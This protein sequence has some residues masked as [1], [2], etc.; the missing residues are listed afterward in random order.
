V[1]RRTVARE[2]QGA[3]APPAHDVQPA[4]AAAGD[5]LPTPDLS[6]RELIEAAFCRDASAGHSRIAVEELD[7]E[8]LRQTTDTGQRY[9]QVLELETIERRA[10]VQLGV[11]W[12]KA[13]YWRDDAA[14]A[15]FVQWVKSAAYGYLDN[16]YKVE[17]APICGGPSQFVALD[18]LLYDIPD[19]YPIECW[20]GT[21][22]RAVMRTSGG[23]LY[24]GELR[25]ELPAVAFAH[26]LG[27]CL[28]G[29]NDEYANRT[30][31]D[32]ALTNDHSIMAD[33][34]VEG[35]AQAEFKVR[36]FRRVAEAIA[37][38]Y[39]GYRCRLVPA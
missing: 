20:G 12:V 30:L 33:F 24:E 18:F 31:A 7:R 37:R 19:G 26:E 4:G 38:H 25:E 14:F 17:L 13:G 16:K 5:A 8:T 1:A 29:A 27:H 11:H 10:H 9:S 28:L 35:R 2:A 32:R 15:A 21:K 6:F 39:P 36:H 22:G 34:N 3:D 23:T